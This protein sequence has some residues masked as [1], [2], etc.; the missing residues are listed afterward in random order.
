MKTDTMLLIQAVI[1]AL[2]IHKPVDVILKTRVSKES[3]RGLAGWCD[4]VFHTGKLAKHSIKINL[5]ATLESGYDICGVIAHELIHAR[6]IEDGS[7]NPEHHHDKRFQVIA[8]HLEK[9]L[10]ELGFET[11]PLYD[12]LTDN[13]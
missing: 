2:E 11:G 7:F 3:Q 1:T 10:N 4:T 6:M 13:S 12:S 8:A 9:I 5:G